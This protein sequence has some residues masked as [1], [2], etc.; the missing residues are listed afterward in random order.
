M[1]KGHVLFLEGGVVSSAEVQSILE[2]LNCE[3][4][5]ANNVNS[6]SSILRQQS[7]DLVILNIED[8]E[9]LPIIEFALSLK[10]FDL[11]II[12]LT[13][14]NNRESYDLA[15]QANM[16]AYIVSPFDMLTL[17]SIVTANL[18]GIQRK[19][20]TEEWSGNKVMDDA[21]FIK[22][23]QSLQKVTIEHITHVRSEGN[24]CLIF[25]TEKKYA[26]KIS[27]VR[28]NQN[29]SE[30]GFIQVHKSYLAKLN[31]IENIDISSNEVII[32]AVRIPLGRKYKQELLAHLNL[33]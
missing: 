29:L 32:G 3:I 15:Q 10:K 22:V 7:V 13:L 18:D 17:R 27:M 12:F 6:A 14:N 1:H 20:T 2:D 5:L 28:L 25:T 33:L 9:G 21:L 16:V 26:I 19:T 11:P 30:K 23:N 24:Y 31:K 8:E 4:Y